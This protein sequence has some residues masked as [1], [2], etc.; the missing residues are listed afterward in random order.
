MSDLLQASEPRQVQR[1]RAARPADRPRQFRHYLTVREL[2]TELRFPSE[3]ACRT[4]LY[5]HAVPRVKR[6]RSLLID[7]RDAEAVLRKVS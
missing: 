1:A 3:D 5:R 2:V 7:L 4:W 6:G